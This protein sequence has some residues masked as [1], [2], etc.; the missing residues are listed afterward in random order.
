MIEKGTGPSSG[1]SPGPSDYYDPLIRRELAKAAVWLG[2]ALAIILAALLAQ[3]LL[4]I[5]G[6]LVF[7]TMLDGG[8]RL[9]GRVL[10]I[11]RGWRLA[12][13]CILAVLF[14]VWT[15]FLAGSQ[16][17][18]EAENMRLVLTQQTGRIL[19]WAEGMGLATGDASAEIHRQIMGS[20]GKVTS[21]VGTALGAISSMAMILV[22]G[23][24]VAIDPRLYER[25]VAW[26]LPVEKRADFYVTTD[27][28]A[29][30]MRRLMAG[31]LLGMAVEGVGTWIL[32]SIAG[33]PMAALLG[34]LTG[35]LAFLPNIG[36]IISGILTI[37][38]GFS[39]GT[40]TG[41]WAI[42]VYA[43]IQTVDGYLI[44]PMVAKRAVD[45]APALVLSAQLLF[46][47]LFGILGLTF[48]DP[49]VAMLKVLLERRAETATE[50][51][52]ATESA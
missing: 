29:Y 15:I 33:V 51:N 2:L 50:A 44:V 20:I 47:A 27:R 13:V 37:L 21:A 40:E 43:T 23:I 42:G 19:S 17:A 28:M 18:A 14:I 9:L 16:F 45:L 48:A 1:E 11:A 12:I 35:L 46:G 25:G 24:F 31:R 38:V 36:S 5:I 52:E 26:M 6:G 22:I 7:A 3:P 39:A 30:T 34:V 32:L 10:P 8:T 41:L 49:I 4:L